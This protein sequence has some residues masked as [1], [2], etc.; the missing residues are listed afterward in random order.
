MNIAAGNFVV[1]FV[2]QN[3]L[4]MRVAELLYKPMGLLIVGKLET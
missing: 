2:S 1:N 3:I 4:S